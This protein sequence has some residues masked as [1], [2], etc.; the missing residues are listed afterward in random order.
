MT[1]RQVRSVVEYCDEILRSMN[2]RHARTGSHK[3]WQL[4]SWPRYMHVY[5]FH[6]APMQSIRQSSSAILK[7]VQLA[8]QVTSRPP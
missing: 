5:A 1:V 6:R 2:V 4:L 7:C 3:S 8:M